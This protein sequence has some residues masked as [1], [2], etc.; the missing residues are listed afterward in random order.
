MAP[1]ASMLTVVEVDSLTD[2]ERQNSKAEQ[3]T[4]PWCCGETY[5]PV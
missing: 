4:G 2:V 1:E 5:R 3:S